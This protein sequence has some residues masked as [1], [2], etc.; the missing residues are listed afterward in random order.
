VLGETEI[1]QKMEVTPGVK[2][3]R[4]KVEFIPESIR[5]ANRRRK[6]DS[7]LTWCFHLLS[8]FLHYHALKSGRSCPSF[9]LCL[10]YYLFLISFGCKA[11][12]AYLCNPKNYLFICTAKS[13]Q[14]SKS[15]SYEKRSPSRQLPVSSF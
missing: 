11:N 5:Y 1:P 10:N 6:P 14:P 13:V 2:E 7:E 9:L 12:Q 3:T 15:K 8:M 4:Q